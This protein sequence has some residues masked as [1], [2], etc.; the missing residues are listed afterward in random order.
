MRA[1]V[2]GYAL[3]HVLS[4]PDPPPSSLKERESVVGARAR[5]RAA[6]TK[7]PPRPRRTTRARGKGAGMSHPSTQHCPRRP[8][9]LSNGAVEAAAGRCI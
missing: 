3:C 9:S 4:W 2:D 6:G 1:E 5:G 8:H 7:S